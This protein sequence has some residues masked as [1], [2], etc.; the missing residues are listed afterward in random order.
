MDIQTR[1]HQAEALRDEWVKNGRPLFPYIKGAWNLD[2]QYG[3]TKYYR[4]DK[5]LDQAKAELES[6]RAEMVQR[7]YEKTW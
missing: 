3:L 2:Y 6:I 1:L 4:P 5:E 7:G